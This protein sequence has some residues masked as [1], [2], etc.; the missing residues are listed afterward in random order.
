MPQN[1]ELLLNVK[2]ASDHLRY[3]NPDTTLMYIDNSFRQQ[4]IYA[5]AACKYAISQNLDINLSTDYHYNSL[6]ANLV[7]FAY[8]VRHTALTALAA[9]GEWRRLKAQA[10][11]LGTFVI[12]DIKRSG[13]ARPAGKTE[14]TPAVFVSYQPFA[15]RNLH[16][17]AFY[18]RIF[19][20]PTFNDL[21]YTDIGNI[22]LKP[23]YANQYN[24]G[25]Q[26]N[27]ETG[28]IPSLQ[29]RADAYYNEITDK[30]VAIPKG[31]GQYRWM[32]MNLG[33]VEIRGIDIGAAIETPLMASLQ[34]RISL[35]YTYQRAQDCTNPQSQ[36]YG[37]QIAYIPR[38]SGSAA[39]NILWRG[40]SANYSF[41]YVGERYHNSANIPPNYEQPWYTHDGSISRAFVWSKVKLILSAEVNNILNQYYDVVLN[42]PMPGR[43]YKF[44][45]KL[46]L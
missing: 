23:E 35:N 31:S 39:A 16:L 42:Y 25:V 4:E 28:L 43:N 6:A 37:G 46:E 26:Y 1:A 17:R 2:Y 18:K 9:A 7:N 15:R 21:Y 8:P 36:W 22:K 20:M 24:L 13:A 14:W 11:V 19:R 32:M 29:I 3:L 10:S 41:I 38:H 12:E 5:S 30:I 34:P 40:W 27:V 44:I 45:L 33:Y